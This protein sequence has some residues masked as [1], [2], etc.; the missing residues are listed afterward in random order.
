MKAFFFSIYLVLCFPIFPQSKEEL[1]QIEK[2]DALIEIMVKEKQREIEEDKRTILEEEAAYVRSH[3][4]G[5]YFYYDLFFPGLGHFYRR[6]YSKSFLIGISFWAGVYSANYHYQTAKH[7]SERIG[8]E[9]IYNPFASFSMLPKYKHH[10][11]QSQIFTAASLGIY[12]INL[13][14]SFQDENAFQIGF[15]HKKEES[16][17]EVYEIKLSLSF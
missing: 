10:N 3:K 2:E 17:F 7:L 12:V 9:S 14:I 6:N 1:T 5:E 11:N 4:V 15:I 8:N 16:N 13:F